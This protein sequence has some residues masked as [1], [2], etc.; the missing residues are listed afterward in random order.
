MLSS[1]GASV[2]ARANP[3]SSLGNQIGSKVC[4]FANMGQPKIE[5]I[6]DNS[7]GPQRIIPSYSTM[8]TISGHVAITAAIETPFEDIDIA[9]IG[10]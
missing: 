7:D 4:T 3:R 8:D 9:F 1:S 5:F 6:M 10:E 2:N